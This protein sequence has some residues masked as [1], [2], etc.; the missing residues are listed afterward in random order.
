MTGAEERAGGRESRRYLLL[1]VTAGESSRRAGETALWLAEELGL[2]LRITAVTSPHVLQGPLDQ[3]LKP[4][5]AERGPVAPV[6]LPT[7]ARTKEVIRVH[8]TADQ[9]L[10][11]ARELGI[12]ATFKPVKRTGDAW[13]G[14]LAEAE[15]GCAMIVMGRGDDE[16][17]FFW[18][19][20]VE[21][22]RRSR[23]PVLLV[24]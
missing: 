7:T 24:P 12:T 9:V 1:V 6:P 3:L 15:E 5:T 20:A 21:V 11:R 4:S 10:A 16:G 23:V 17:D 8:E 13:S 18:R 22:A 2:D 14:I 19:V